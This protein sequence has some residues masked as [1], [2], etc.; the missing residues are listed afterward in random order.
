MKTCIAHLKSQTSYSQSGPMV[1]DKLPKET[2]DAY[3]ERCWPERAHVNQ[4]G[5]VFIPP[6]AF[7]FGLDKAAKMLG[8]QIPGKG[9]ATYTKFFEQGVLCI[10]PLCWGS[11]R[12]NGGGTSCS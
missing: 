10:E 9:K 4:D 8:K 11:S 12:A 3:E 7:K 2:P 6:M 1:S 5:E